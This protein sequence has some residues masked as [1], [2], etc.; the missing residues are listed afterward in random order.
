MDNLEAKIYTS[1]DTLP[2]GLLEDNFFHSARF[3]AICQQTPRHRPY[4]VTLEDAGGRVVAQMLAVVRYR[5]SWFPPYYYMHCRI[6]GE[7]AY[8]EAGDGPLFGQMLQKLTSKL[9]PRMLYVEVS[10]LSHKM[11]GYPQLC[12][13]RYFPVRWMSIH[14][15]L[16][17][18]TPEERI[19]QQLQHRIDAA[20]ERGVVTDEVQTPDDFKEF[21]RLL[22]HHNWLKPKRYIPAD[23]FFSQ[24]HEQ[25]DVGRLY[26]TRYKGHIVGCSAVVYSHRQAY[27]WYAAYRRKTYAMVHPR[28]L[29]I[30]H[31]IKDAHRRGYEH[32]FFMDVGLPFRKN[33]FRDFILRFGGKPVSTYRWFRFSIKWLNS[34]LSRIYRD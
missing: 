31:A 9:G 5:T 24:L 23:E 13:N 10:H 11:F 7:G 20:Y 25:P 32:I 19:S 3:F 15:S 33:A 34:L 26:V 6:M 1:G 18:R 2:T 12:D 29:T 17:S 8:A 30:W 28:E 4:L 21:M 16:H 14:N 22:R 27:L